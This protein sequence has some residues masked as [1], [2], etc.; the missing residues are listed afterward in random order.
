MANVNSKVTTTSLR[1]KKLKVLLL[2]NSIFIVTLLG[3][4]HHD[5]FINEEEIKGQSHT[6]DKWILM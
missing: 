2:P 5:Y 1:R 3:K 4:Y 6:A